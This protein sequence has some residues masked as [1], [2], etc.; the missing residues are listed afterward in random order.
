MTDRY[1]AL[2]FPMG[3]A[4]SPRIHAM[5]ARQTGQDLRY[6][7]IET[8]P[9]RFRSAV[10]AFRAAGGR[11]INVT[12]PFKIEAHA[13]AGELTERA[14]R[15]GAVNCIAFVDGQ[16]IGENFD[17]VGLVRDIRQPGVPMANHRV[18]AGAGGARGAPMPLVEQRPATLVL[19]N[20]TAARAGAGQ[21][22]VP[23][24]RRSRST[25]R[26]SGR[27]SSIWSQRDVGEHQRPPVLRSLSPDVARPLLL[28][29]LTPFL[30]LA[31]DAGAG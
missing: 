3:H 18:A 8:P 23:P 15:A 25:T 5:F 17:G 27:S 21:G 4:K 11:G 7:A 6:D 16:A 22:S 29:W 26:N 1:A 13:Y 20:R 14:Q 28:P 19:A 10:D 24:V 30:A 12:V 2:G 9:G 31:R